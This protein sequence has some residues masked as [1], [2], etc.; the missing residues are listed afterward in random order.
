MTAPSARAD[1]VI[2][3]SVAAKWLVPEDLS[4]ESL[5]FLGP[6]FRR[7]V[8]DWL[9]AEVGQIV[10]KK[11]HQRREI[12]AEAGRSILSALR[13]APLE[14]HPTTPLLEP[15]FEIALAAGRSLYDSSY[16]ALAT[17][18]DCRLVT[19]DRRLFNALQGGPLAS[20]VTWVGDPI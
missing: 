19:A 3:A 5:R 8:P 15:A 1:V 12:E 16:L 13:S 4:A 6:E 9:F 2:D 14:I 20:T 17:S 11:V 18:L 10:W 7:H